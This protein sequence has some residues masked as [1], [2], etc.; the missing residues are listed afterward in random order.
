[1]TITLITLCKSTRNILTETLTLITFPS[2]TDKM[3]NNNNSK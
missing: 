2:T 3:N 1:M